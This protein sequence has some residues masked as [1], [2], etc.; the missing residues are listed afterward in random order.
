MFLRDMFVVN[1]HEE[2]F[3]ENLVKDYNAQKKINE[4]STRKTS[5]V[6][7]TGGKIRK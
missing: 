1:G 4:T 6:P 5:W 2:T 7:N 3:L